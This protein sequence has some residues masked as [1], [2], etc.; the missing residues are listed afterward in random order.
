MIL[1]FVWIPKI[2]VGWPDCCHEGVACVNPN[3][4]DMKYDWPLIVANMRTLFLVLY[5]A[6]DKERNDMRSFPFLS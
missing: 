3:F 1:D 5:R 2:D 6:K 4:A